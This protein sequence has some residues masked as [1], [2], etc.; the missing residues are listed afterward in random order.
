ML[1]FLL[2][3]LTLIL[4]GTK[5]NSKKDIFV[6]DMLTIFQNAQVYSWELIVNDQLLKIIAKV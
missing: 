1:L 6:F 2:V 4:Q 3:L 5:S